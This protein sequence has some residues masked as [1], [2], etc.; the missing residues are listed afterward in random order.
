MNITEQARAIAGP[1]IAGEEGN[2]LHAY[3]DPRSAMGKAL[4]PRGVAQ[5][6]R[7]GIIPASVNHLDASPWTIGKGITGDDVTR[8]THWSQQHADARFSELLVAYH[9]RA[10]RAWP[11]MKTL[12]P[13]AQAALISLAYNRGT[14]LKR[15]FSDTLDRRREMRELVPAVVARDYV[16]MSELFRSMTRIWAGE[17]MGGLIKRRIAEADLCMQAAR[18]SARP[19]VAIIGGV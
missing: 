10:E 9:D 7:T 16:R 14:G 17:R 3:P 13:K 19:G 6:G 4:G 5:V 18:E 2:Y 1:F 8:G 15:D 11:G 12:H